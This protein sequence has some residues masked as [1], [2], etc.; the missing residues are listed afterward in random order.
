MVRNRQ[1]SMKDRCCIFVPTVQ[2]RNEFCSAS[3][4]IQFGSTSNQLCNVS[5]VDA[6]VI[7]ESTAA[8][9]SEARYVLN[10]MARRRV[11]P[12][13][14]LNVLIAVRITRCPMATVPKSRPPLSHSSRNCREVECQNGFRHHVKQESGILRY[15]R[16]ALHRRTGL[17][18][19]HPPQCFG[20]WNPDIIAVL[21][22]LARCKSTRDGNKMPLYQNLLVI[23]TCLQ[24]TIYHK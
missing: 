18:L 19:T 11:P 13:F 5:D 6:T 7:W 23:G 1:N 24:T 9:S 16:S 2:C 21:R 14:S 15:L 10:Q 22:L 3:E 8:V 4:V 20:A 12:V 17:N